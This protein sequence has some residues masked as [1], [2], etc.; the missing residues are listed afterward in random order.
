MIQLM[1]VV[2]VKLH[3]IGLLGD[4]FVELVEILFVSMLLLTKKNN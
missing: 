4:I 2:V 1:N 3:L